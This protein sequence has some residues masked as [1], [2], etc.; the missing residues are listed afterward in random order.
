MVLQFIAQTD[1]KEHAK[2][3]NIHIFLTTDRAAY[4]WQCLGLLHVLLFT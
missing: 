4:K 2:G 3:Q 1:D